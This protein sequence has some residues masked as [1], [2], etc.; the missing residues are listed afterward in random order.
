[1][2]QDDLSMDIWISSLNK[3]D[4]V[5]SILNSISLVNLVRISLKISIKISKILINL[6]RSR[7]NIFEMLNSEDLSH[8]Y[9]VSRWSQRLC[10]LARK[11]FS[12]SKFSKF[13]HYILSLP[14]LFCLNY[15]I[16]TDLSVHSCTFCLDIFMI[17]CKTV[18]K[19]YCKCF[20][21]RKRLSSFILLFYQLFCWS[22]AKFESLTRG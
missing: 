17:I 22:N 6:E 16:F 10:R 13:C 14:K 11:N 2:I 20:G 12:K 5:D 19:Y 15:S 8:V 9:L 7:L 1:M 4:R 21:W 3:E 18:K